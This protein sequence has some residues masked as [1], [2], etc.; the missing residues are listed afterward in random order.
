VT[1]PLPSVPDSEI[2]PRIRLKPTWQ[3]WFNQLYTYVTQTSTMGGGLVP[4]T[5]TV[6]TTAPLAGGGDLGSDRTLSIT[7]AGITNAFLAVMANNTVKGNVSGGSA[8]PTDLTTAQLT[9]LVQAFTSVLSGAVPASGGGTVNVLRADGTWT[10]AVTGAWSAS[11]SVSAGTFLKS[12]S[13]VV[14]SLP[15]AGTAGAGAR[16]F[17][18]DATV[19]TFASVVVGGGAN[20]VPVYSDGTNW[21]IG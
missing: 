6:S 1:N 16:H 7:A 4:T 11:T 8:V 9:A 14:G 12:A 19:T 17:V 3:S 10:N 21:R 13:T 5:R 15:A 20:A 18:T 2:A